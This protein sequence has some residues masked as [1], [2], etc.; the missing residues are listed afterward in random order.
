MDLYGLDAADRVVVRDGMFRASWHWEEGREA[1]AAPAET[2]AVANYA[3]IFLS[4]ICGWLAVRHK[5]RMRAEVFDLAQRDSLRVVRF[6]LEDGPGPATVE[7]LKPEGELSQILEQ[8]G[9][10]L[11]VKLG[12]SLSGARELRIHGRHE[13]VIIKP[14]AGR[15]WMGVSALEDADAVV[16]ESFTGGTA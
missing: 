4:V 1:S 6:I 8:I 10:R 11:N 15:Y 14:S 9:K 12:T 13:V 16:A 3:N 2:S 7:V 5:R